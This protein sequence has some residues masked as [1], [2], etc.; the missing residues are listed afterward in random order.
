[1]YQKKSRDFLFYFYALK[2]GIEYELHP[3]ILNCKTFVGYT[4]NYD[5]V[6]VGELTMTIQK[7]GAEELKQALSDFD[8][9]PTADSYYCISITNIHFDSYSIYKERLSKSDDYA[10]NKHLR[11]HA[12]KVI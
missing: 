3:E 2:E 9:S 1:M 7:S 11:Q 12:P 4:D 6:I 8:F 5:K 10:Y